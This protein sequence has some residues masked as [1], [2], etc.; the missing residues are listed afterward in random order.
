[1]VVAAQPCLRLS[2]GNN[3]LKQTAN[4]GVGAQSEEAR[5]GCHVQ[6]KWPMVRISPRTTSSST[7]LWSLNW[8]QKCLGWTELRPCRPPGL[9]KSLCMLSK[10]IKSS[11]SKAEFMAHHI[12]PLVYDDLF[13]LFILYWRSDHLY[14]FFIEDQTPFIFPLLKIR[15]HARNFLGLHSDR[16]N[17][18][19]YWLPNRQRLFVVKSARGPSYSPDACF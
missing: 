16:N 13:P 15:H 12:I 17:I 2:E 19:R 11:S 10:R 7:P 8:H 6:P 1:M 3:V 5:A 9:R 18:D 4:Y 14:L